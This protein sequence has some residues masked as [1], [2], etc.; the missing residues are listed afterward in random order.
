MNWFAKGFVRNS[1]DHKRWK[2][3]QYIIVLRF[4]KAYFN[5][6]RKEVVTNVQNSPGWRIEFR[7]EWE[8]IPG[9]HSMDYFVMRIDDRSVDYPASYVNSSVHH[10]NDDIISLAVLLQFP[11]IIKFTFFYPN[12]NTSAAAPAN[13]IHSHVKCEERIESKSF[14]TIGKGEWTNKSKCHIIFYYTKLPS[15]R[16]HSRAFVDGVADA[17]NLYLY[18]YVL[19]NAIKLNLISFRENPSRFR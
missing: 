7:K 15:S 14:I 9:D 16:F 8:M 19:E 6:V 12:F 10:N 3:A 11:I 17:V 13:W 5:L 1:F 2:N 4:I 18:E